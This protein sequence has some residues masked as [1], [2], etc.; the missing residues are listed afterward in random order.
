M[1][2]D[3]NFFVFFPHSFFA[4][5]ASDINFYIVT[6]W[7]YDNLQYKKVLLI[8]ALSLKVTFLFQKRL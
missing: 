8:I 4:G 6:F 3:F 2:I 1:K 5:A 7:K